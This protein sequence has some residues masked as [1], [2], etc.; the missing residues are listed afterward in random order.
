MI[1][2]AELEK[3]RVFNNK[4][5]KSIKSGRLTEDLLSEVKSI[6]NDPLPESPKT[7]AMHGKRNY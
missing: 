7:K 2:E 1:P 6:F 3:F 5:E 4:F